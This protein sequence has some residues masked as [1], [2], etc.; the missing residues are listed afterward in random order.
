MKINVN[1]DQTVRTITFRI[2]DG[3]VMESPMNQYR[4]RK[5]RFRADRGWVYLVEGEVRNVGLEGPLVKKDGSRSD[6][7]R[8][9][10]RWGER[11]LSQ[12]PDWLGIVVTES[13]RQVAREW[14]LEP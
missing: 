10:A 3:P 1:G 13:V 8:D 9:D 2:E 6:I 4:T 11:Q 14:E 7:V 12:L 5:Q